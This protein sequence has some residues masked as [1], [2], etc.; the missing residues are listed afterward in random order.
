MFDW[1]E[2]ILILVCFNILLTATSKILGKIMDKTPTD[3]DNK[4][5]ALLAKVL[6]WVQK[7][8]DMLGYNPEH[9]D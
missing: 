9:K 3:V 4:A 8:L 7:A 1:T 6:P 2:I 5:Y